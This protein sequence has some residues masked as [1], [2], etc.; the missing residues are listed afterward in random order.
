MRVTRARTPQE[1]ADDAADILTAQLRENPASVLAL[2]T[3]NTPIGLYAETVRRARLGLTSLARANLFNLDEYCGM[4]P[5]NPS[6]FAAF[7]HR[8]LIDPLAIAPERV[9]LL[10]GDVADTAAECRDYDREIAERGG[11][12]LCVLGLGANGHIAFNEPGSDWRKHTHV[13]ALAASTRALLESQP[14]GPR[15]VPTHGIT[16]G[17]ESIL[18]SRHALLL[19]AG[20]D[21]QEAMAALAR[22][23]EDVAWP[24]TALLRH[25][26][27]TVIELCGP[28]RPL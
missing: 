25:P 6:S 4:A 3:G 13:T 15:P 9:R 18:A 10:K 5:D 28:D 12:D 17:I 7:L 24:V 16:L 21:K 27:L 20:T 19:I 1:F 14:S 26:S 8:H 2:P 11:I 23:V 22:G